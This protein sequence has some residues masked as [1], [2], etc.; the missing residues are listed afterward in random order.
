MSALPGKFTED[1]VKKYVDALNF[2]AVEATFGEKAPK[3]KYALEMHKH[4]AFLQ[5]LVA[6][7]EANVAEVK[8]VKKAKPD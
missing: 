2:V 7:L 5:S 8:S 4:F 3:L 6:K 1:D